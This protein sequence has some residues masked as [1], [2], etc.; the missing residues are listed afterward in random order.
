VG[1]QAKNIRKIR[2]KNYS[3][4]I[5]SVVPTRFYWN[6][7]DFDGIEFGPFDGL[8]RHERRLCDLPLHAI[9]V[10]MTAKHIIDYMEE[11]HRDW[12]DKIIS[13]LDADELGI[14]SAVLD[15]F[16]EEDSK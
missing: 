4:V 1:K 2:S 3:V 13:E 7:D 16:K 10:R 14:P 8:T 15:A 5:E 12:F 11:H 9:A 6:G